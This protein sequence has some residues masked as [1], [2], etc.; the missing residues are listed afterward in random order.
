MFRVYTYNIPAA[1]LTVLSEDGL[2]AKRN[3]K[4]QQRRFS[5]MAGI[6]IDC[7]PLYGLIDI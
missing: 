6:L 3:D 4:I 2:E 7:L 5:A 1:A